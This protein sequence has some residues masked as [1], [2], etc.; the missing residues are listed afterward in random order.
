MPHF[1]ETAAGQDFIASA[2]SRETSPEIM[3]A[4]AYFAR[5]TNEAEAL[6]NGDGFGSVCHPS[7]LWERVTKNGMINA[8]EFCWGA[9]TF[10]AWWADVQASA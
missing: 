8:D 5:N 9:T 1:N 3:E 10:A 4:I 6:W 2:A 7:D